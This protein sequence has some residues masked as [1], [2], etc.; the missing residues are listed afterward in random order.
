M[1]LDSGKYYGFQIYIRNAESWNLTQ[2]DSWRLWLRSPDGYM[3]DG[4]RSLGAT[5]TQFLVP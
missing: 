2:H 5:G 4:S 1:A 3:V